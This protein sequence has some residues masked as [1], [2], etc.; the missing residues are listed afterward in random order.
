MILNIVH[1]LA[2]HLSQLCG[3]HILTHRMHVG[4]SRDHI[5]RRKLTVQFIGVTEMFLGN[6]F[7]VYGHHR[8][9]YAHS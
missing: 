9:G 7:N 8:A 4:Q 2:G 5:S 3:R 1:E 6:R